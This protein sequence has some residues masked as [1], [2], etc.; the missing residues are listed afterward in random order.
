MR[1]HMVMRKIG[2][3]GFAFGSLLGLLFVAYKLFKYSGGGTRDDVPTYLA[4]IL[5]CGILG[6]MGGYLI[7]WIIRLLRKR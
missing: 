1:N 3:R 6:A 4:M 7:A 5:S 2:Y